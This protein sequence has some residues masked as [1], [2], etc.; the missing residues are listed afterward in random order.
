MKALDEYFLMVAFTLSLNRYFKLGRSTTRF[1]QSPFRD[2][3]ACII[4]VCLHTQIFEHST[5]GLS[6]SGGR[7]HQVEVEGR[8]I[9]RPVR[10]EE[11]W[12]NMLKREKEGKIE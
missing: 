2:F 10:Q 3:L 11:P 4:T 12:R 7:M 8:E 6:H 1:N 5:G 9:Q